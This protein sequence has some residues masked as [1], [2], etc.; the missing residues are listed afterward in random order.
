MSCLTLLYKH[1][2]SD[3]NPGTPILAPP[4]VILDL[5][6]LALSPGSEISHFDQQLILSGIVC[7]WWGLTL[8]GLFRLRKRH[9]DEGKYFY[10]HIAYT[11]LEI[12]QLKDETDNLPAAKVK[13]L[14]VSEKLAF[15]FLNSAFTKTIQKQV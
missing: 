6:D 1:I 2:L 14:T 8:K 5:W 7:G 9:P 3:L 13:E 10:G 11:N 4:R 15:T 12:Q